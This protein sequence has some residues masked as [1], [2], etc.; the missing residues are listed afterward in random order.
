[1]SFAELKEQV[2]VLSVEERNQLAAFLSELEETEHRA[3]INRRMQAMD[4]GKKVTAE[5]FE[6]R[7][8]ELKSKGL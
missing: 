5:E 3:V 8:E 4:A 2:A 6:A 1:M 7:H